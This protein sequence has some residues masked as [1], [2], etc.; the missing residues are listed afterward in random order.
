MTQASGPASGQNTTTAVTR[1][2]AAKTGPGEGDAYWFF[3]GRT[4][5]RSPEGALPVVIEMELGPG[6][7]APLHVHH[8]IDDSFYLL[9]G[10]IAV[11]CGEDVL[12]ARPGDYVS[13]PKGVPHTFYVLDDQPA[14]ILQTHDG[15]SF[16]NFIKQ[17]GVPAGASAD[18]PPAGESDME[19]ML[20]IAAATGQ[21]VI[22]PPMSGQ[23]VEQILATAPA[24]A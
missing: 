13:Q 12:V 5:I 7:H 2:R 16:L 10:R 17:A 11:R 4:V 3:G 23:E 6:G 19:A 24:P 22:G 21:P 14:V 8:D 18:S 9:S 1:R 15:D 20:A